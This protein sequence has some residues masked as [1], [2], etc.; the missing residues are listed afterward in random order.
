MASS[1]VVSSLDA[2]SLFDLLAFLFVP[3]VLITFF[4]ARNFTFKTAVPRRNWSRGL[5]VTTNKFSLIICR[6]RRR[7][8][9]GRFQYDI[10]V[11]IFVICVCVRVRVKTKAPELVQMY[12]TKWL[13]ILPTKLLPI[14]VLHVRRFIYRR[15]TYFVANSQKKNFFSH[16]TSLDSDRRSIDI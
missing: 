13:V 5:T 4:V 9:F 8:I 10:L 3:S 16:K 7:D 11:Y 2:L 14:R 1:V 12:N 15:F 6:F